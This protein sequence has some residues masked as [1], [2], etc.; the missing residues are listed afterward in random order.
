M[1]S[2]ELHTNPEKKTQKKKD[3]RTIRIPVSFSPSELQRITEACQKAGVCSVLQKPLQQRKD[4][5]A[6]LYCTKNIGKFIRENVIPFYYDL[7][8]QR[9]AEAAKLEEEIV[10]K[11]KR[12]DKL[13][14]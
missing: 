9:Q 13:K 1:E 2:S 4:T 7:K 3:Y 11:Q 14:G 6:T 8:W 5:G 10:E 12:L